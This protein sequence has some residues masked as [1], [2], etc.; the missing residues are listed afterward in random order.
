M[1]TTKQDI[2]SYFDRHQSKAELA[3]DGDWYRPDDWHDITSSIV[4]SYGGEGC[5]STYYHVYKFDMPD[6]STFYLRFDGWY[7][8]H[9]GTDY[10]D[11]REVHP[12]QVTKTEFV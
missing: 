10:Q 5:G 4:D 7:A 2:I 12:K 9:Y 3:M 11:F 1:M 8:S 6:G